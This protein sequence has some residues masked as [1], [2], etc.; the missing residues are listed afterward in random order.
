MIFC[1]VNESTK[2]FSSNRWVFCDGKNNTLECGRPSSASLVYSTMSLQM[3]KTFQDRITTWAS[4]AMALM[5]SFKRKKKDPYLWLVWKQIQGEGF[6]GVFSKCW[7]TILF[8]EQPI[9]SAQRETFIT[10]YWKTPGFVSAKNRKKRLLLLTVILA[11]LYHFSDQKEH[12]H[13]GMR[14]FVGSCF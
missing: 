10:H 5:T 9:Q 8:D 6:K 7:N 1:L 13:C 2:P 11:P 4:E 14:I 3:R 12:C